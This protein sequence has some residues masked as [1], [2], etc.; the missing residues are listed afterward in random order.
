MMIAKEF[1][2]KTVI[3]E[4]RQYECIS[5]N[6]TGD[7]LMLKDGKRLFSVPVIEVALKNDFNPTRAD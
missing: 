4:E 6:F 3:F 2:G 1:V 5:Y 7:R